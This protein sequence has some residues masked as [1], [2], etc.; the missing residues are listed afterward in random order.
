MVDEHHD[1]LSEVDC[2][3]NYLSILNFVVRIGTNNKKTESDCMPDRK[4]NLVVADDHPIVLLGIEAMIEKLWNIRLVGRV[5][6]ST[7]LFHML[8]HEQ[9]DIV[10]TD[11]AMPDGAFG[12]GMEM[13]KRLRSR[14]PDVKIIV[15]TA[16]SNPALLSKIVQLKI[17]GLLNKDSDL[18]EIPTAINRVAIG[19]KYFGSSLKSA[20]ETQSTA[21][22]VDKMALL[23]PKEFEVLRMFLEGMSIQAIADHV[24]RSRKTISNQKRMGMLKLACANDME[25]FLLNSEI[26]LTSMPSSTGARAIQESE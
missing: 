19:L 9:V 2:R 23:S 21:P 1:M 8:D 13:L 16:L 10:L 24:R 17:D 25:L 20:L 15:L 18:N 12:D 4:L 14:F 7:G 3:R 26:G 22:E 11:Y 6:N 5:E